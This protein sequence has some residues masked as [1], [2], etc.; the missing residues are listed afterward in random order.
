MHLRIIL[1][2][3]IISL[4][5]FASCT[6]QDDLYEFETC[7]NHFTMDEIQSR[8]DEIREKYNRDIR[9]APNTNIENIT[10][11]FFI[12][13]ENH[14]K[15]ISKKREI[16]N[17]PILNDSI[18]DDIVVFTKPET[19]NTTHTGSFTDSHIIKYDV[20]VLSYTDYVDV[21]ITWHTTTTALSQCKV[22]FEIGNYSSSLDPSN[23]EYNISNTSYTFS[24]LTNLS[25]PS[26]SYSYTLKGTRKLRNSQ[27]EVI[28]ERVIYSSD[29]FG[30]HN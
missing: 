25:N 17:N 20:N 28:E 3:G 18:I 14:Y 29:Y 30:L 16:I 6:F 21:L 13:I 15:T 10:E 9:L 27:G 7:N 5:I 19:E 8:L 4:F 22:Q 1:T 2:F 26:F 11:M 12:D 24:S 23:V